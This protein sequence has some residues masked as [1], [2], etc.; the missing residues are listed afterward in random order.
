[1]YVR[2]LH[3]IKQF[4]KI[5]TPKLENT[6]THLES[7]ATKPTHVQTMNPKQFVTITSQSLEPT[8]CHQL[9]CGYRCFMGSHVNYNLSHHYDALLHNLSHRYNAIFSVELLVQI[10]FH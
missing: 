6:Y 1:L 4:V 2:A 5:S 10:N 3:N 9:S 7:L 8:I